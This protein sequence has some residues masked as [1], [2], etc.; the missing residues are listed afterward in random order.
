[1]DRRVSAPRVAVPPPTPIGYPVR[2]FAGPWT[3]FPGSTQKRAWSGPDE[4]SRDLERMEQENIVY[5]NAQT[6]KE[7]LMFLTV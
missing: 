2:T 5:F 6:A 1:M 3:R 7:N 4:L